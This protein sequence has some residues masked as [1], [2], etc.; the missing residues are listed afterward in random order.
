MQFIAEEKFLQMLEEAY[1]HLDGVV[2]WAHGR[3][4]DNKTKVNWEDDR[5]QAIYRAIKTFAGR[6]NLSNQQ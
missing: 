6:H 5:V 1:E 2:I 3:D 4:A